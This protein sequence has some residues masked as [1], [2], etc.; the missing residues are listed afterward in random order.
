MLLQLQGIEVVP[1]KCLGVCN[2]PVAVI[3][4]G[5]K[6]V[7]VSEVDSARARTRLQ[8]AIANGDTR[9]LKRYAVGGGKREKALKRSA[10]A[11]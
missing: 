8:K 6:P 9:M 5:R 1:T 7:V 10:R 4:L 11:L 3:P 2:G